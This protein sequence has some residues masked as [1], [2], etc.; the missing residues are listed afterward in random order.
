MFDIRWFLRKRL[1]RAPS[2]VRGYVA[3]WQGVEIQ[4]SSWA[5]QPVVAREGCPIATGQ[6]QS[7]QRYW[8]FTVQSFGMNSICEFSETFGDVLAIDVRDQRGA[9]PEKVIRIKLEDG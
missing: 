2:H 8:A 7:L 4:Q 9:V 5:V 6:L 1:H 3:Y